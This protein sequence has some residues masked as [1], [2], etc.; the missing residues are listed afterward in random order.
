LLKDPK[1]RSRVTDS[2]KWSNFMRA[3]KE[4]GLFEDNEDDENELYNPIPIPPPKGM[5]QE[6]GDT[7]SSSDNDLSPEDSRL[8]TPS[9]S[10]TQS[11][12]AP[13]RKHASN[14]TQSRVGGRD[15]Q[16][17]LPTSS[18][19]IRNH[20]HLAA[21]IQLTMDLSTRQEMKLFWTKFPGTTEV[22]RK[23]AS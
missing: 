18:V 4:S 9:A 8:Q 12:G 11:D 16:T 22:T 5:V 14:M 21:K 17:T 1:I 2:K 15:S 10:S 7:Y 20:H 13:E 3:A 19:L 23:P 6:T